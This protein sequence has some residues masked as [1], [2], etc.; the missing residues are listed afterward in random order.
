MMPTRTRKPL[1]KYPCYRCNI[2]Q[3]YG[4]KLF[5]IG[6]LRMCEYCAEITIEQIGKKLEEVKE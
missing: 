4:R 6:K 1:H 5:S 2:L 3:G